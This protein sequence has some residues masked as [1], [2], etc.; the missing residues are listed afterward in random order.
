MPATFEQFWGKYRAGAEI[1]PEVSKLIMNDYCLGAVEFYV[2]STVDDSQQSHF[3]MSY[4]IYT[5]HTG[6]FLGLV[7]RWVALMVP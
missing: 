1:F 6:S 4:A 5:T 2:V 7:S 3:D